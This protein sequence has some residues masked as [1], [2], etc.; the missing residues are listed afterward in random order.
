MYHLG[1]KKANFIVTKNR[2]MV[3]RGWGHI[4]KGKIKTKMEEIRIV[5]ARCWEEEVT[6]I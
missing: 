2:I 5:V 1:G 3:I 4:G 6:V